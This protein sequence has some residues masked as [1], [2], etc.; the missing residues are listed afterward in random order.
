MKQRLAD[1]GDL[2]HQEWGRLQIPIGAGRMHVAQIGT[3][4]DEVPGDGISVMRALFQ[5][6]D[7]ERMTKIVNA[8][9]ALAGRPPQAY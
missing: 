5:G 9:P 7:S 8:W 3:E 1:I 2:F 6:A 4:G